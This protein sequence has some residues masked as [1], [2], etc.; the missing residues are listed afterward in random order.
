MGQS[1]DELRNMVRKSY[2]ET[3]R[4]ADSCCST[5]CCGITR[6]DLSGYARQLGYSAEQISM[7]A[8]EA[9]LGLGCGNPLLAADLKPGETVLD[10]GS[11][12]AFDALIAA[13]RVGQM[14]K[15]IGTDMTPEMVARAIENRNKAGFS[16]VH[17]IMAH[18]EELPLPENSVDVV[19]SNCVVNLS[20]DKTKV[21]SEMYRVL[22]SGGRISISDVLRSAELPEELRTDPH[23]Y[24]G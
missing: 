20:P 5:G 2:A 15:V 7:G 16:N 6:S 24:S 13:Q 1:E 4:S 14:G 11:G 19:V 12:A 8:I 21:N 18:I 9:N 23:A 10:L 22:K 3:A 17:F